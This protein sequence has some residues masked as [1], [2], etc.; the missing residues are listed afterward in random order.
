MEVVVSNSTRAQHYNIECRSA[1]HA[2]KM[3]LADYQYSV[4]ERFK[5]LSNFWN[6]I[7]AV[8]VD[9]TFVVF[10]VA[11]SLERLF[12]RNYFCPFMWQF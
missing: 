2:H 12:V 5:S 6:A 4:T 3:F 1:E 7:V 10:T 8:A 11:I 9:F